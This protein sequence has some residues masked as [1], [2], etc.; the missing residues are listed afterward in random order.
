MVGQTADN[1]ASGRPADARL[2]IRAI[3][4]LS[5]RVGGNEIGLAGRKPRALIAYLAISEA[6]KET[7]ER[8]VGLLWGETEEEKARSSLRQ[9]LHEIRTALDRAGFNGFR[10]DKVAITLDHSQIDVDLRDIFEEAA[11]GRPHPVLLE[12]ER[13]L[14]RL[15]EEFD[16]LDPGFRVWLL[17]KR[18]S[19]GDRL[20]R[21]LEA[22][23][24]DAGKP[25]P[26]REALA[27]A[28]MSLDPT[29]EEA[30]RLHIRSRANAGDIGA[31]LRAYKALWD[32]LENEYDVEPSK[33]TQELIAGIKLGLPEVSPTARVDTAAPPSSATTLPLKTPDVRDA[34]LVLSVGPFE[35]GGGADA[36][37][38]LVQGF[39]HELIACL[40]RFR[41]WLVRDIAGP[42][43]V[44]SAKPDG[45]EYLIE[46]HAYPAAQ[47]LRLIL[48]LRDALTNVY[49]W[50]ER[51][52]VS[53]ANWSDAQQSII[54]RIATAL[55]VHVSASRLAL[56]SPPAKTDLLTYDRWLQGQAQILSFAAGDWHQAALIFREIIAKTPSFA[57]A[58]SSLAQLNNVIHLTHHGVFRNR[59][60]CME[61]LACAR[62]ATNLDPIDSRSHLA[63][64]WA[65][66][67]SNRHDLAAIH[68]TLAEELN[69]NDPWTLVSSGLGF[70][71]SGETERA[72][73]LAD[74][75]LSLAVMPGPTHWGYQM[76]IRF[77]GG[78]LAGAAEAAQ[79][80]A[81]VPA[82][83]GWRA[84]LLCGLGDMQAAAAEL[85][86][87]YQVAD[88]H[89]VGG[90][91][92]T[93]DDVMSWF[94]H[95]FPIKRREDWERLRDLLISAGAPAKGMQHEICD[96]SASTVPH[97]HMPME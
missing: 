77:L 68:Y 22:A 63:L 26:A 56:I 62:E 17:A 82:F 2:S 39:R 24:G 65:H 97:A 55:N 20:M 90:T 94:L 75:A 18:Q 58:Y 43:M 49:L 10:T 4:K 35:A 71:F 44:P 91:A 93:R 7:R 51:V 86:R 79:Y 45:S 6:G 5:I 31:A 3:G 8:L 61:A 67:M 88:R 40:V 66:L 21:L 74:R 48:T 87:F 96:V 50:S 57:P 95:S 13:P 89:W 64:G 15:L 9:S 80:A 73:M 38:Y 69:D 16:S 19:L 70:A 36:P 46:A 59:A 53:V 47:E 11:S 54:R 33:E 32:L 25:A 76:R 72:R 28:L 83:P 1:R 81:D 92:P 12:A 60:R 34:R 27:R 84:A 23:M 29:H 52:T 37:R 41:E 85:E 30:A 42:T 78:D 14:D